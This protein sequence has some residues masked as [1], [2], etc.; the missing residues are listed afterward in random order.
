MM[1]TI[2]KFLDSAALV[3]VVAGIV[4]LPLLLSHWPPLLDYLRHLGRVY[5]LH[6]LLTSGRFADSYQLNWAILPNLGIDLSVLPLLFLGIPTDIAGRIFVGFVMVL[7]GLS[8][9]ALHRGLFATRSALPLIAFAFAYNDVLLAGF[10]NYQLGVALAFLA[11]AAWLRLRLR[12]S[13]ATASLFLTVS[14]VVAFFCH[15][16]GALILLG[17]V[18]SYET[19]AWLLG[20]LPGDPNKGGGGR[21]TSAPAAGADRAGAVCGP[22]V[23]RLADRGERGRRPGGGGG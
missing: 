15:L 6:D 11:F 21:R 14:T 7:T 19:T 4:C 22:A 23:G 2:L 17:L 1:R 8:V 10:L 13:V 9:V 5:V 16:M 3:G 18:L 12:L 20:A